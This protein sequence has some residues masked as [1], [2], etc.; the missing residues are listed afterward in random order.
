[1]FSSAGAITAISVPTGEASP[2]LARRFPSIPSPRATRS[3]IA[4][5]VSTSARTSPDFTASPSFLSHFVR[6]PSSIVGESASITT[7]VAISSGEVH[8]FL[9]RGDCFRGIGLRCSLEILC[10]RHRN[11]FLM[12]AQHRR[13]EIVETFALDEIH[14]LRANAAYLPAFLEN[15][16]AIRLTDRS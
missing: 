11:I 5:S 3:M 12:H 16:S 2:S 8:D 7:L 10:V 13:V 1:M 4:L 6:R 14:R 9:Y 15:Y